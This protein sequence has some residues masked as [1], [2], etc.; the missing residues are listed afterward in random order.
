MSITLNDGT[1]TLTLNPDLYW[2]DENDWSPVQ[3]SV[4]TTITGA[5]DVQVGVRLAGRPITLQPENESSAWIPRSTVDTLRNW[6]AQPAKEMTLTLRGSARTV[7]FRHQD[8]A[9][10]AQPVVHWRDV[11]S[12]DWYLCTLRFMEV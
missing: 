9:L 7:I 1:T 8:T 3:Q 4:E 6:A 5:L 10:E 11:V 12:S 2:A